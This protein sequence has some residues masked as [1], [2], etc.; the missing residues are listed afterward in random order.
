ILQMKALGLG[1]LDRFPFVEPPDRRSIRDGMALLHEL[2]A[3]SP[4]DDALTEVGRQLAQLPV[5]PR[6]GR[7]IIEAQHEGCVRD[8]LVIAAALSIPD[9]RERPLD[10]EEAARAKHARFADEHS[11]FIGFLN[12]WR[13]LSDQ[14]RERS[15]NQFRRMCRDEFLH[16]LR[17][18]EWQ[19]LVGQL[20]QIA[21]G[22]GIQES[23]QE[24]DPA[25]IHRA[26][27]SGL[28]SHIGMRDAPDRATSGGAAPPRVAR[29]ASRD[30]LGAR[31]T[32]FVI[33]PGSTLARRP[34][35]WVVAAE[36]VETSRLFA[37]VA[38]RVDPKDVE[39]QA[40]HLVV[41][42]YSEPEW[43]RRRG[44]VMVR[45]R[46][47]LFGLPLVAGRRVQNPDAAE[48][49]ELFI[50]HALVEGDWDTRH[51]FFHDNRRLLD[52]LTAVEERARRRDLIV[53]DEELFA[54]YDR[55]IPAD[56]V[57]ARHFD[58]WWKQARRDSPAL[59]TL[60]R[61][62]VLRGDVADEQPDVWADG[63][64]E[65]PV[66]YRFEPGAADDGV[67]VHIPLDVLARIG[68]AD[69][70]WQVPALR[71]ELVTA[72][73]RALPKDI[74][75]NFVP[76]PD[77]A[78]A[79]LERMDPGGEPLLEALQRELHR[80]S[81]V[82]VPLAAFDLDKVPAH[83]RVT[84][85]IED[86]QHDVIAAGKDLG[87]LQ[88][89]LAGPAREAVASATG[90]EREGLRDWPADLDALPQVV[91]G[92]RGVRGYPAFVDGGNAVAIRVFATPLEQAAAAKPG[93]RRLIR[94]TVPS[95][96]K[97]I[98]V[99]RTGRLL[100]LADLL[101]DCADAA[102]DS[103]IADG[104]LSA[105]DGAGASRSADS[106]TRDAFTAVRDQ[107]R[108]ELPSVTQEIADLV[109]RVLGAVQD[110]RLL[111]RPEPPPA[112]ADAITD[113]RAQLVELLPGGF[114]AATG[115]NRLRDLD[116]YV[117]AIARRAEKLPREVEVDRARMLRVQAVQTAFG[118]LVRALPA[119]R[120][121]APDVQDIRWL[122]EELR[123]SLFA[124]QLGT[125]RP[126]SEQRIYRAID[127]IA[128]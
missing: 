15:G 40:G 89:K 7:M 123:V 91:D 50:R 117:R 108:G 63:D 85:A 14:R 38:A 83:L 118:A 9:P 82:L 52:E 98:A 70:S 34:P 3:L 72:L 17:I 33:S 126:V 44:A 87:A 57:S 120:A 96:V 110:A 114:V 94:L 18:R 124:Q 127:A 115:R 64:V 31:N 128:P 49:R 56:V 55:R 71:E 20:R 90:L 78:R 68:G 13:Y 77:T 74:R 11:D 1:D 101:D 65:L 41:R 51:H 12:L 47:T 6:I 106:F 121:A 10:Q 24:S 86:A 102:V 92:A 119:A 66:T 113:M 25:A 2:G 62:D 76:A 107:V 19:D 125:S 69:F 81:G 58:S 75:R 60:T 43:D 73:I 36:L 5:D 54:F 112:Q 39:R 97:G 59:L 46:V 29:S 109:E 99:S 67:T 37:R 80:R 100:G 30:Y 48:S 28:L 93:L 21:R 79:V 23:D 4:S 84:F 95:P 22:L 122:I 103:L 61:E 8:V 104:K 35:E 111:L 45:E 42:T 53:D 88:A 27:L 26:L 116:R 105:L 32:R 16:Y